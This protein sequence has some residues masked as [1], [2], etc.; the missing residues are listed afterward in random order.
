MILKKRKTFLRRIS[1]DVFREKNAFSSSKNVAKNVLNNVAKKT[2]RKKRRSRSLFAWKPTFAK[3]KTVQFFIATSTSSSATIFPFL[4]PGGDGEVG[5]ERPEHPRGGGDRIPLFAESY[6]HQVPH[7]FP[8]LDPSLVQLNSGRGLFLL[9]S[10]STV[11][12]S[13]HGIPFKP[14]ASSATPSSVENGLLIFW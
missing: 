7:P 11:A 8:A 3:Q 9:E 10:L 4:A 2:S 13:P 14:A 5:G 6:S 12:A 1:P